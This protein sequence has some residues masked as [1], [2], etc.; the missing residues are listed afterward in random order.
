M[1]RART[2]R[3][4]RSMTSAANSPGA[5]SANRY[6]A[7]SAA[8][9]CW[10]PRSCAA[11]ARVRS[12][13]R[14]VPVVARH[15]R[16][17]SRSSSSSSGSPESDKRPGVAAAGAVDREAPLARPGRGP[18]AS[19][20]SRSKGSSSAARSSGMPASTNRLDVVEQRVGDGLAAELPD[21]RAQ[22]ELGVEAQPVVDAPRCCRRRVAEQ[23]VA[24]LAVGVV[25][26]EVERADAAAAASWQLASSS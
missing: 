8:G 23:A 7:Y 22:L 25:G 1:A 24:A 5:S 10:R 26:D 20:A 2:V 14:P 17:T 19:S 13:A 15:K 12:A 9:Q 3:R 18:R 4:P 11:R 6:S 16:S 21:H